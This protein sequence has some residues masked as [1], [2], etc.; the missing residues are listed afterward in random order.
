MVVDL[1]KVE[2]E[3]KEV[4][5]RG[6]HHEALIKLKYLGREYELLLCKLSRPVSKILTE[7]SG[8]YLII[9]LVDKNGDAFGSCCVH[10]KH[11]EKG[12]LECSSLIVP[13][14]ECRSE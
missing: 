6:E 14:K 8:D 11:L 13:P 4:V 12:C 3:L 2:A 10:I 5:K 1:I 9:K 7:V